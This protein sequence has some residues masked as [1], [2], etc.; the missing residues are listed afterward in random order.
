MINNLSDNNLNLHDKLVDSHALSN[1]MKGSGFEDNGRFI[2]PQ[3]MRSRKDFSIKSDINQLQDKDFFTKSF[4]INFKIGK[5]QSD[6]IV[7][8]PDID[9]NNLNTYEPV[10]Q[11]NGDIGG[12]SDEKFVLKVCDDEFDSR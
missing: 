8:R 11:D 2:I 4:L 1:D 3:K 12:M 5:I 9:S 10:L 7:Q 6:R